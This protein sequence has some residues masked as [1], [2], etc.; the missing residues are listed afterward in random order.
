MS[1]WGQTTTEKDGVMT[2]GI[3]ERLQTR[4]AQIDDQQSDDRIE[5]HGM[6]GVVYFAWQRSGKSSS[7]NFA[8][9][10]S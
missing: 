6:V 3:D 5:R 8:E 4:K 7:R 10:M 2:D 9:T 1:H